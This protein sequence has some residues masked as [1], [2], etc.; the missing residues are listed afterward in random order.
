MSHIPFI[1]HGFA[2]NHKSSSIHRRVPFLLLLGVFHHLLNS[3][4]V[5]FIHEMFLR[6]L[7]GELLPASV[8]AERLRND[9]DFLLAVG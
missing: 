9:E 1:C 3:G 8:N 6:Q 4:I 5:P 7:L 2:C